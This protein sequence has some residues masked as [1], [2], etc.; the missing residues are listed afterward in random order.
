MIC[1]NGVFYV[2][3]NRLEERGRLQYFYHAPSSYLPIRDVLNEQG[4]GHKTE[5]HI[6]VGAENLW[7]ACFQGNNIIPHIE[8]PERYLFLMTTCRNH[9]F[10]VYGVKSV[11]GYIDKKGWGIN[12]VDGKKLHYV[13]GETYMFPFEHAI[14]I[15]DLGYNNW[16]RIKLVDKKETIKILNRFES[17][18]NILEQCVE[19][20][21]RIDTES[22]T[23]YA[24]QGYSCSL[25]EQCIRFAKT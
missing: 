9:D 23:C 25:E 17:L 2:D 16:S 18:D 3:T 24:K 4:E 19:E 6:E 11:V 10:D 22:I 21:S 5:P 15:T 12:D 20:I 7:K 13:F 1:D 8:S 14:P